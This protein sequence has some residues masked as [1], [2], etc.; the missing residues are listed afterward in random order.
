MGWPDGYIAF[1]VDG[2]EVSII[3]IFYGGQ[4]HE[5]LLRGDEPNG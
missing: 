4:D 2:E 5:S 1:D 3:G